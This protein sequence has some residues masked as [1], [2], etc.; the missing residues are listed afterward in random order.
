MVG[1]PPLHPALSP[2]VDTCVHAVTRPVAA[3]S[4]SDSL[5]DPWGVQG[6][7]VAAV[8]DQVKDLKPSDLLHVTLLSTNNHTTIKS[9]QSDLALPPKLDKKDTHS[10]EIFC[11]RVPGAKNT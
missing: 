3:E 2:S 6:T 4:A 7:V 9:T 11:H 8:V 10:E 5:F 1:T